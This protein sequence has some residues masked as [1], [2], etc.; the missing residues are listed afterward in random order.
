[1]KPKFTRENYDKTPLV[2]RDMNRQKQRYRVSYI[3]GDWY[4]RCET[5]DY[6]LKSTSWSH[7]ICAIGGFIA[8]FINTC[9]EHS[10][11]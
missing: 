6:L 2:F 1:M 10:D 7:Q 11:I 4:I 5:C 3:D 9:D 8:G